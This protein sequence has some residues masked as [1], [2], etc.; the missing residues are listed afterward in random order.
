MQSLLCAQV[1]G[2]DLV[3][4]SQQSSSSHDWKAET[5]FETCVYKFEKPLT[6]LVMQSLVISGQVTSAGQDYSCL[7]VP[8][9]HIANSPV[10]IAVFTPLEVEILA[11]RAFVSNLSL[12]QILQ[13]SMEIPQRVCC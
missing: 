5:A 13:L 3:N 7:S 2:H 8:P 1:N 6:V 4:R 10:R 11:L 12:L 9:K